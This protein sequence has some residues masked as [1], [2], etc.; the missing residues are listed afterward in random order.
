M[1][2]KVQSVSPSGD[3]R[4]HKAY[5]GP[6]LV[7]KMATVERNSEKGFA[8]ILPT[9]SVARTC[10]LPPEW[11]GPTIPLFLIEVEEKKFDLN[12]NNT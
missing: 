12:K 3:K 8:F 2:V 5:S 4:K 9:G 11:F 7:L 1:G 6:N 10:T